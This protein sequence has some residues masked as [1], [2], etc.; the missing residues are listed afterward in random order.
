MNFLYIYDHY[1]FSASG[2][3]IL[4]KLKCNCSSAIEC[5]C[6]GRGNVT[7]LLSDFDLVEK[8]TGD[9]QWAR[10]SDTEPS[11]TDGMKALEVSKIYQQ[12]IIHIAYN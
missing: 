6:P 11:G 2:S 12:N 8:A 9:G 1:N 3:N 7:A 10:L 5:I 4:L